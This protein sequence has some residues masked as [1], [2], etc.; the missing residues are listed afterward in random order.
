MKKKVF[1]IAFTV[2]VLAAAPMQVIGSAIAFVSHEARSSQ[3][4]F[5]GVTDST[6]SAFKPISSLGSHT[7]SS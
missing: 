2:L 5:F 3:V 4:A 6:Y 1:L 7:I